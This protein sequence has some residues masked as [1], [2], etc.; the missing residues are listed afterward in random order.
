MKY[1]TFLVLLL[2]IGQILAQNFENCKGTTNNQPLIDVDAKLVQQ[3]PGGKKYFFAQGDNQI[4]IVNVTGTYYEMGYKT[5]VLMKEEINSNLNEMN[6]YVV[7]QID[8]LLENF[9]VPAYLVKILVNKNIEKL[10]DYLLGLNWELAFPYIP[11]RYIDEMQGLADGS[12]AS[13]QLIRNW[14]MFPELIKAHCTIVGAW[15]PSTKGD[16]LLTLRSL[17][18]DH[19]SPM[20][21]NPLITVYHPTQQDG[22]NKSYPFSNIGYAGLI[23]AL[24][25]NGSQG[26][27][28]AEK[29]WLPR[30]T[31]NNPTTYQGKPWMFALRDLAEFELTIQDLDD[32]LWNTDRTCR[33]HVGIASA[34]SQTF[35]GVNYSWKV[36]EFFNDQNYT[37][38]EAHPQLDGIMYFDK[39]VQPSNDACIGDI[40]SYY[41]GEITWETLFRDVAGWHKTGDTQVCVTDV[42]ES[43]IYISY[44]AANTNIEAH[45]RSPMKIDLR[46]YYGTSGSL[47]KPLKN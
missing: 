40:L 18:F 13:F 6:K 17:D 12:Q 19:A 8:D 27:S 4:T 41:W 16:K 38:T 2:I 10:G 28:V 33:I 31:S 11:T 15:A 42:Y 20:N 26:V 44:S 29:V 46:P 7:Q 35:Q 25:A 37:Y 23:G 24:T 47:Q 32:A 9:G 14:N 30:D 34:E 3:T 1:F 43:T 45:E 21:K 5:G 36:I 39:H 22:E